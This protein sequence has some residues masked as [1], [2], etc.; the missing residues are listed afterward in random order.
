MKFIET[1]VFT[2]D[3]REFLSD[4]EYRAL[5]TAL[6]LRP[7]QGALIRG[8]GGLRKIRWARKGKGKRG[9]FRVI[10]YWHEQTQS[11][12]MLLIYAKNEQEELTSKQQKILSKLGEEELYEGF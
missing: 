12:Y 5:Q 4:E 11:S 1:P 9:G 7:Q 10:Y 6:M 3:I 8:T 2:K